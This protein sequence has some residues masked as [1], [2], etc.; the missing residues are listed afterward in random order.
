MLEFYYDFL[1]KY[2]DRRDFELIQMDTDSLYMGISG[3]RFEDIVRPELKQQFEAQKKCWV[4][5]DKWSGW[6]PGLFKLE[7]EGSRTIALCSKC[8]YID[9]G[10]GG[11][12]KFSMKGMSNTQNEITWER[13]E[14]ALKGGKDNA[15]NRG[16]RMRDGQMVTY[17]QQ[18]LGLSGYY[19]KRWV[20]EDGIHTKPIEFHIS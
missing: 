9:D 4:S 12:K 16:F 11:K 1:N 18:K 8:Y 15:T 19:D 10:E 13:F 3:E 5:W 7:C 20:L 17:E 2:I 14:E 6:T